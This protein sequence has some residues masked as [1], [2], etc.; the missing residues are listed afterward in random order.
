MLWAVWSAS[1]LAGAWQAA[2]AAG[3]SRGA[4]ADAD[5]DATAALFDAAS[6]FGARLPPGSPRLFLDSLAG[7]EIA[8][9]TLAERSPQG[10][11]V[12]VLTAHRSKGLEW[13]L[14]VV[15]G[16]QEGTWPDLRM[17]GSLLGMDEL[18]DAVA[19]DQDRAAAADAA[20][21]ALSAKLLAEE[22]R[23]FYVAVTR[24][25][26]VL[27]VTA[28]EAGKTAR[29]GRPGSS[30]SWPAGRSGSST[31]PRRAG[32]GCRCP[33]SPRTCAAP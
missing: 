19:G 30:P 14:V 27:V 12:A 3:G 11:A 6:R 5:L 18:V 16:V 17:R 22:R 26:R 15:A 31:S 4:A 32:A 13:D 1:G 21:A 8:G 2:S 20:A 25:R 10:D 33:R 29:T 24:A 7:Q 28:V 23:L 9:D